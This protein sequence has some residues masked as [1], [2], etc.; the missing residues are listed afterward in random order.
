MSSL[1]LFIEDVCIVRNWKKELKTATRSTFDFICVYVEK[2][3]LSCL[4]IRGL[5]FVD[6]DDGFGNDAAR[7]LDVNRF[8]YIYALSDLNVD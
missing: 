5:Q 7:L 4:E 6:D 8:T 2:K 3:K 1:L